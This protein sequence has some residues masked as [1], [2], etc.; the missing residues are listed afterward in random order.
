[1]SAPQV[2]VLADDLSG[3]ADCAVASTSSGLSAVV[4][5]STGASSW[6]DVQAIDLN[7][8]RLSAGAAA[9]RHTC[10]VRHLQYCQP[11]KPLLYKKINSTLRG[12]VAA[13]IAACLAAL[14]SG[15]GA[16]VAPAFPAAGRTTRNG[17]VY[18]H[19]VPLETT[20]V[21]RRASSRTDA[22]LDRLLTE[23]GLQFVVAN[24]EAVR[25]GPA[26]LYDQF[27]T[28]LKSGGQAIICDAQTETDLGIVGALPSG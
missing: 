22:R 3:A 9:L 23:V 24:L 17:R 12:H 15:S 28:A 8:R 20:E 19:D 2:V 5:L 25:L 4:L 16:V 18:I 11:D 14:P 6:A 13:E 10:L 21:W 26:A 1:M 7:T 27:T